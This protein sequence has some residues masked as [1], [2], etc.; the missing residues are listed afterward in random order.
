[1]TEYKLTYLNT[2]LVGYAFLIVPAAVGIFTVEI[3]YYPI[4]I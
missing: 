1:M 4:G 2:S 3:I